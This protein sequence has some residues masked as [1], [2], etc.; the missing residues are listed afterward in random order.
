MQRGSSRRLDLHS[1]RNQNTT[2]DGV[3]HSSSAGMESAH[4][5]RGPD[6]FN[7]FTLS[8]N[9]FV[10]FQVSEAASPMGASCMEGDD[11]AVCRLEGSRRSIVTQVKMKSSGLRPNTQLRYATETPQ[12]ESSHGSFCNAAKYVSDI[13][14]TF[15]HMKRELV[16]ETGFGGLLAVPPLTKLN[17]TFALWLLSKVRWWSSSIVVGDNINMP[18]T[19]KHIE[20]IIGIP[21]TGHGV[22]Q[23]SLAS[24][25]EKE[26]FLRDRLSFLGDETQLILNAESIITAHLPDNA[27]KLMKDQ[28]KVAF[29]IFVMGRFLAPTT[30]INIGNSDFW[31]ALSNPDQIHSFNWA[32][33]VLHHIIEASRKAQWYKKPETSI[34]CCIWVLQIFYLDNLDLGPIS[35]PHVTFP[36]IKAFDNLQISKMIQADTT[37]ISAST[38]NIFGNSK[39]RDRKTSCYYMSACKPNHAV[40]NNKRSD[41]QSLIKYSKKRGN[42]ESSDTCSDHML[43][44]NDS[45]DFAAVVRQRFKDKLDPKMI[46]ALKT[47]NTKCVQLLNKQKTNSNKNNLTAAIV[48]ENIKLTEKIAEILSY[49]HHYPNKRV[50]ME[51]EPGPSKTSEEHFSETGSRN[52]EVPL[53]HARPS[54]FSFDSS[55]VQVGININKVL[56]FDTPPSVAFPSKPG[57]GSA[58]YPS[59]TEGGA[60]EDN[61]QMLSNSNTLSPTKKQMIPFATTNL[62][63]CE[64]SKAFETPADSA[65]VAPM[66]PLYSPTTENKLYS[67]F[68]LSARML[69]SVD[70]I[71]LNSRVIDAEYS[72]SPVIKKNASP[73]RLATS[74]FSTKMLS[75]F[76]SSSR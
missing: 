18:L 62:D 54:R 25:S 57:A 70:S 61:T 13:V 49:N 47:H 43:I 21:S 55:R 17:R 5:A 39:V 56:S 26:Q 59:A 68:T 44:D 15:G 10:Q 28:F 8:H 30:D 2:A 16:C 60:K 1:I 24:D 63:M 20:L 33:Y 50:Q 40:G 23:C 74:H 42:S 66:S 34:S 67:E 51:V 31:G 12:S 38:S 48:S 29:V 6:L 52:E 75:C 58:G 19:D 11:D 69:S 71:N 14:S 36:R 27:P 35:V 9:G 76:T 22:L 3:F 53:H 4:H 41:S 46:D 65:M 64:T 45:P 32:N 37:T 72:N 7:A 73:G